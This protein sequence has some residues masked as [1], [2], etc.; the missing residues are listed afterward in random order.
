MNKIEIC[1]CGENIQH[2]QNIKSLDTYMFDR[3]HFDN[4]ISDIAGNLTR[5]KQPWKQETHSRC[6][7]RRS[8]RKN[9]I[10]QS[11]SNAIN[12]RYFLYCS[13]KAH[14]RYC[15]H[16]FV[17][18]QSNFQIKFSWS[19]CVLIPTYLHQ[20]KWLFVT[21]SK[22]HRPALTYKCKRWWQH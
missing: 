4:E 13:E 7:E 8:Y 16:L 3:A 21:G 20:Q 2:A 14:E 15:G 9:R 5:T 17:H 18:I 11:S 6:H 1:E 12:F 10:K 22:F 19:D